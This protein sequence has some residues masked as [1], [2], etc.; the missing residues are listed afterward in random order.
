MHSTMLVVGLPRHVID[1]VIQMKQELCT[2]LQV[3]F[4]L[5][6]KGSLHDHHLALILLILIQEYNVTA[7]LAQDL[8]TCLTKATVTGK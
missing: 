7:L 4:Q 3:L 5:M 8:H 1:R 2:K 6:F